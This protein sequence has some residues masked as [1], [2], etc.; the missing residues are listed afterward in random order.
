M[1]YQLHRCETE[2][3]VLGSIDF[4]HVLSAGCLF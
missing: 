4:T 3:K 2:Y 1:G